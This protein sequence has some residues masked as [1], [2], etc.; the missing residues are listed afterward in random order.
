MKVSSPSQS[1]Q[2]CGSTSLPFFGDD[3]FVGIAQSNRK[4]R[5][6]VGGFFPPIWKIC[7]SNWIISPSRGENK[8]C[9]KPPSSYQIS[10]TFTHFLGVILLW[11]THMGDQ[12]HRSEQRTGLIGCLLGKQQIRLTQA[13]LK[14]DV[15]W[16]CWWLKS[17]K[18]TGW[19]W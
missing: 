15:Y 9:L 12:A 11:H 13:E 6:I 8:K 1:S 19:G 16:Y 7:S 10:A 4:R 3:D 14:M 17:G 18:L 2:V 5:T